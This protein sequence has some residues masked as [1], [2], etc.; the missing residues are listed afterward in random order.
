MNSIWS[1]L[2]PKNLI[3]CKK[4]SCTQSWGREV[5][6]QYL[7]EFFENHVTIFDSSSMQHLRWSCL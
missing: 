5:Y 2:N 7:L 3:E 6:P 4:P 1:I